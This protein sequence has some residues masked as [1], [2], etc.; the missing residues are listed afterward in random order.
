MQDAVVIDLEKSR[1]KLL[2][3]MRTF[4]DL[5]TL[6]RHSEY[7]SK[8]ARLYFYKQYL[9]VDKMNVWQKFVLKMIAKRSSRKKVHKTAK[10]TYQGTK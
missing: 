8:S 9:G 6:N 2:P 1:T 4:Y 3:F 5:S 7:W 10:K